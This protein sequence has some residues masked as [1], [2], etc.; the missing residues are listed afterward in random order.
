MP[1]PRHDEGAD[2]P[3]LDQR[4]GDQHHAF[5]TV[6]VDQ[7]RRER[8]HQAEQDDSQRKRDRNLLGDPAEFLGQAE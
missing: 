2:E 1:E 8:R 3:D 7:R 6:F 5:E 4:E